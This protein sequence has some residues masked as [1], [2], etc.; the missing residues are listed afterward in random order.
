M[1]NEF[2]FIGLLFAGTG[3]LIFALS[4]SKTSV[5]NGGSSG[6]IS[7]FLLY[8]SVSNKILFRFDAFAFKI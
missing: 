4:S 5:F 1:L 3:T 8:I 2:A 7:S 6:C